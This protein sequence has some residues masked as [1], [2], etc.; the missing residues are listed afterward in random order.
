MRVRVMV[1]VR[2]RVNN[3]GKRKRNYANLDGRLKRIVLSY[4]V[5]NIEE[6]FIRITMNLE[7]DP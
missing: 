1:R 5:N 4:N 6:Y 2:V 7:I 3:Q